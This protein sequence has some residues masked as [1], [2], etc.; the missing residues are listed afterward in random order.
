MSLQV[1]SLTCR[2]WPPQVG[3]YDFNQNCVYFFAELLKLA[4]AGSWCKFH[5]QQGDEAYKPSTIE[6]AGMIA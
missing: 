2:R 1:R 5:L 6:R 4:V 3:G